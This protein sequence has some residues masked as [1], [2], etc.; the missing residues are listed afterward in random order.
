MTFNGKKTEI[1]EL[2]QLVEK[3][4][5][6]RSKMDIG[7]LTAI[8]YVDQ[9]MP[10]EEVLKIKGELRKINSLKIADAGYPVDAGSISP[11]LYHTVALPRV[12]PPMDARVMEKEDIARKGI[13]LFVIDLS[14]RN[15]TPGDI[16]QNLTKFIQDNEG[17]KYVF[18]LEYDNAIPYGQ[19]IESVDL[20][21]KVVYSFRKE[22]ALKK[23]QIPYADL[24][25]DLQKEIR[26]AY[27]MVLSEA[28]ND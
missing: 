5:S 24:G 17:G 27:P 22:L 19:Y 3:E 6:K 10:M 23:Y 8:F 28:W 12:L 15:T 21:F 9:K 18:S 2:A 11:L 4:R 26:K 7:K 20:V 13:E 16:D 1:S 25:T 14:A